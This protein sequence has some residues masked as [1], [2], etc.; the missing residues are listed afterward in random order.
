MSPTTQLRLP[1]LKELCPFDHAT[2]PHYEEIGAQ[3]SAWINSF[4]CFSGKKHEF[5]AQGGSELL[6]SH[7]YPYAG[8][9]ELRLCCDF[10]NLLVGAQ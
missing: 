3:S 2:N 1:N 5:F 7:V 10:I 8:R 6:A 9:E 4:Q